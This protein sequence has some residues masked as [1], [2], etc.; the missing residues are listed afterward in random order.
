MA[1]AEMPEYQDFFNRGTLEL[2]FKVLRKKFPALALRVQNIIVSTYPRGDYHT[3]ITAEELPLNADGAAKIVQALS[4]L[5]NEL[6]VSGQTQRV[7]LAMIRSLLLDWLMF[8]RARC[9]QQA[10][11]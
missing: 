9:Y 2:T 11:V 10:G 6:A 3:G 1:V 7:D 5:S 4:A 8:A